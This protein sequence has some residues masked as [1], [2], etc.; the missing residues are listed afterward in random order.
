MWRW[1]RRFLAYYR[2][3]L[4]A[5][6]EESAGRKWWE[7][8]HTSADSDT[9]ELNDHGLLKCRRCGKEFYN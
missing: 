1:W 2:L 9:D 4:E 7:D 6:C 8:F 3:S 5:V